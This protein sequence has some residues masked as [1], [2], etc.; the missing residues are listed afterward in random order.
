MGISPVRFPLCAGQNCPADVSGHNAMGAHSAR[1]LLY[2]A[3]TCVCTVYMYST[4]ICVCHFVEKQKLLCPCLR[5][6][7]CGHV[8]SS[9]HTRCVSEKHSTHVHVP[10]H[11]CRY[12][13]YVF[14]T[15]MYVSPYIHVHVHVCMCTLTVSEKEILKYF[16]TS[17]NCR[18]IPYRA[19]QI[20][21]AST[22]CANL[23]KETKKHTCTFCMA[24]NIISTCK[25]ATKTYIHVC[26]YKSLASQKR[27]MYNVQCT[28]RIHYYTYMYI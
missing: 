2:C 19:T 23:E 11:N 7:I 1:R 8:C 14:D 4:C 15:S 25:C 13:F 5:R 27:Y 26:M 22:A 21:D 28:C 6:L 10:L 3:R 9:L 18:N 16:H 24:N 12:R 17:L 20:M